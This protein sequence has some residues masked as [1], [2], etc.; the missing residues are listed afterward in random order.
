MGVADW[1]TLIAALVGALGG[2]GALTNAIVQ[3]GRNKAE[4]TQILTGSAMAMMGEF[5]ADA[6]AAR[7]EA[8]QVRREMAEVATQARA[9]AEELHR[10]RMAIMR[11]D[12]TL[13]QLRALVTG[14]AG[15][16]INGRHI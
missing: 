1:A 2:G 9:I 11:P 4:A 5:E 7:D 10:L 13:E 3:R 6:K 15:G 14:S 12:A 8:R 16:G